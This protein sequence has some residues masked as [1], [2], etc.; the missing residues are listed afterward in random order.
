MLKKAIE[1]AHNAREAVDLAGRM[2]MGGERNA[3]MH[4][5]ETWL[6]LA[7]AALEHARFMEPAARDE[8][9]DREVEHR[10]P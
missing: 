10:T 4:M 8:T 7:E 5:A 9:A 2:P 6:L 3:L 1:Y